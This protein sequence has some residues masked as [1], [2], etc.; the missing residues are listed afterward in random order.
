MTKNSCEHN[1]FSILGK[2]SK[3]V[4]VKNIL[5]LHMLVDFKCLF[6][7]NLLALKFGTRVF[8]IKMM[9]WQEFRGKIPI[10]QLLGGCQSWQH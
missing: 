9:L 6:L 8:N 3:L 4:V 10:F 1:F 5:Q 2:V 7:V